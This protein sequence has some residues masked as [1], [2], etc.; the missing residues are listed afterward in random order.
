MLVGLYMGGVKKL[1]LMSTHKTM[2]RSI[3]FF[4][5]AVMIFMFLVATF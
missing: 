2:K 1:G 5:M 3:I 4:N